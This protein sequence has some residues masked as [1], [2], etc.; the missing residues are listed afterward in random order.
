LV[1]RGNR[2]FDS[3]TKTDLTEME[4]ENVTWIRLAVGHVAALLNMATKRCN[5]VQ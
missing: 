1:D 3:S 5:P 4:C 2:R